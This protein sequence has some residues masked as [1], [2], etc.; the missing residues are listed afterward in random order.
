MKRFL[1]SN[2]LI[3]ILSIT[4][5]FAQYNKG[6]LFSNEGVFNVGNASVSYFDLAT[7]QL[8][9]GIYTSVNGEA[10]GDVL[11]NIG[12]YK[13]NAYLVV[14]NSNKVEIVDRVTFEKKATITDGIN[15]PRY[16]AFADEKYFVTNSGSK[17]IGIYDVETNNKLAEIS[18]GDA[19]VEQ[20]VNVGDKVFVMLAAWGI[21][22]SI[23]VIDATTNT[24]SSTITVENALQC[25]TTYNDKVYALCATD[26]GSY[27]QEIDPATESITRTWSTSSY[28]AGY[29]MAA[30]DDVIYYVK[31]NEI[32]A[33]PL[34]AT[35]L[36]DTPVLTVTDNG[37]STCYGFNVIAGIM[38]IS[39][40]KGVT[41]PSTVSAY[42][43]PSYTQ[44]GP[45]LISGMGTNGFYL[46]TYSGD[47]VEEMTLVRIQ[48]YPNPAQ[49]MFTIKGIDKALVKIHNINGQVCK[50]V[51]YTKGNSIDVSD[52]QSGIYLV[53]CHSQAGTFIEKL[54][55]K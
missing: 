31:G 46:S 51:N 19:A 14:N 26:A 40:A 16:I 42:M 49:D 7:H 2:V 21:G 23:M 54:L 52:L 44:M 4:V 41:E 10:L 17:T 35:S 33:M 36:P 53:A 37:W 11:Q 29:K 34:S 12:F 27:I 38:L 55:I 6:I 47:S 13:K 22:N 24:I 9:N 15:Q 3:F 43:P 25:I 50:E 30:H 8:T 5:S 39:D 1:L 18:S 20:I 28:K 45:A 48:A 32:Y